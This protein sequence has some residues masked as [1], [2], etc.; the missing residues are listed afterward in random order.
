MLDF[1][2]KLSFPSAVSYLMWRTWRRRGSINLTFRSGARFQ[3]RADEATNNDFGVFYEVFVHDYYQRSNV[4]RQDVT[5]I[6][7]LGA[8]VGSSALYFLHQ[9]P[10]C[11]IIAIEPHPGHV[12][13]LEHNLELDKTRDRVEIHA[14]AAGAKTRP[15]RLTDS[16]TSSSLTKDGLSDTI[17]VEVLDIFPLI[18]GK[19]IDVLKMDIEGG[20]YELLSDERFA[21]LDIDAIVMEWHSRGQ[22]VQDKQWCERRLASLGFAI[23]EIFT[24]PS[25]GMFWAVRLER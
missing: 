6:V 16:K 11:R 21:L 23:E 20:E 24:Q 10:R 3:L 22:G 13:Q 8:N 14:K 25:Y 9:Y 5:L 17:E 15:M 7:D 2:R 12:A 4:S 18:I 19:H 1:T